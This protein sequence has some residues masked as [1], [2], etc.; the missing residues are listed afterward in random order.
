[1]SFKK[2]YSSEREDIEVDFEERI[3]RFIIKIDNEVVGVECIKF[4][5]LPKFIFSR[6]EGRKIEIGEEK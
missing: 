6:V 4:K 5:E 1:M 3:V 2:V